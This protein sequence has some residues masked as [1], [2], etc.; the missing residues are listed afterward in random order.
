[1]AKLLCNSKCPAVHLSETIRDI[2][3]DLKAK[4]LKLRKI[5]INFTKRKP[6]N[7]ER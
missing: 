6:Y 4:L 3:T 5:E 2:K 1:M 7:K